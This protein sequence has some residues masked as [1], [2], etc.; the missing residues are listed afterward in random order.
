ML[1]ISFVDRPPLL[2][3]DIAAPYRDKLLSLNDVSRHAYDVTYRVGGLT[4]CFQQATLCGVV[5]IAG[6]FLFY[7]GLP[8]TK[9]VLKRYGMQ[10]IHGDISLLVYF[11]LDSMNI[12]M[13]TDVKAARDMVALESPKSDFY[14]RIT[15]M[16]PSI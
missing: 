9:P 16:M 3:V 5:A 2:L 15:L 1:N 10:R 13:G 4:S 14:Q 12:E 7:D 6:G 11:P 8:A